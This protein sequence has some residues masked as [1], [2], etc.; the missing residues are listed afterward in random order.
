MD[1][2][3]TRTMTIVIITHN[4]YSYKNGCIESVIYSLLNQVGLH[5]EIV[6]VDNCSDEDNFLRA[7]IID[8]LDSRNTGRNTNST[9][10][11][12]KSLMEAIGI[13]VPQ[14]SKY[15]AINCTFYLFFV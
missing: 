14:I 11:V 6:V 4:N 12:R 13:C 1:V 3:R 10:I 2:G 8:F 9:L 7:V 15:S 5:F